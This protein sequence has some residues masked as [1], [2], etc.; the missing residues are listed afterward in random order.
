MAA[1]N[2]AYGLDKTKR[3]I[4]LSGAVTFSGFSTGRKAPAGA[5]RSAST[6]WKL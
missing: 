5:R 1:K 3:T 4:A 2:G 6:R